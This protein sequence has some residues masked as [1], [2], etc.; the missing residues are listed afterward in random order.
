MAGEHRIEPPA[1]VAELVLKDDAV[2]V[3]LRLVDQHGQRHEAVLPGV[4][5]AGRRPA[6]KLDRVLGRQFL[7]NPM[8][9]GIGS[10]LLG[11]PGVQLHSGAALPTD[12]VI[13]ASTS[14]GTSTAAVSIGPAVRS[15]GAFGFQ[16][17]SF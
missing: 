4:D 6:T 5:L 1:G 2:V 8:H 3:Q 14:G 16:A 11:R 12:S 9:L 13:A 17:V 7:R 15:C 10:K